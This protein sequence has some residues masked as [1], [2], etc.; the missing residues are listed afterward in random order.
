[1]TRENRSRGVG[2]NS[3]PPWLLTSDR[4][5]QRLRI[6]TPDPLESYYAAYFA[7]TFSFRDDILYVALERDGRQIHRAFPE[8]DKY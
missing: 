4:K 5:K 8:G 7:L 2:S 1:V 3:G 6:L